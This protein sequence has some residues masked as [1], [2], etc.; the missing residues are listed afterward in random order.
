V[1]LSGLGQCS[2]EQS[3]AH[4]LEISSPATIASDPTLLH[5][6]AHDTHALDGFENVPAH[7]GLLGRG[8]GI[9]M[10][11]IALG[12]ICLHRPACSIVGLG[13]VGSVGTGWGA[14]N[15]HQRTYV[16]LGARTCPDLRMWR[17]ARWGAGGALWGVSQVHG[18]RA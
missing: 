6:G 13:A 12:A 5:G 3:I 9:D 10:G 4:C 14:G 11:A 1:R 15:R 16:A 17:A 2:N 7:A 8:A 18:V